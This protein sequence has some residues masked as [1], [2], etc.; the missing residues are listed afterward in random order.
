MC[1][2]VR[3][4]ARMRIADTVMAYIVMAY[5]VMIHIVMA[6]IVVAHIVVARKMLSA[7]IDRLAVRTH[8]LKMTGLCSY[9]PI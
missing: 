1:S 9:D 8:D 7:A 5:V 2:C 6:H 4:R 3:A